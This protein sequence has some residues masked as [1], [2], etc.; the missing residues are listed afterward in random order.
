[1]CSITYAYRHRVPLLTLLA[2]AVPLSPLCVAGL[3][4]TGM[5]TFGNASQ[6]DLASEPADYPNQDASSG[7]DAAARVGTLT[8]SGGGV[9]GFDYTKIANDGTELP[10]EASLGTGRTDWGCVRDNVTSLMWEVKTADNGPR[11]YTWTYTWYD[12]N[13]STNGGS[14]GTANGGDCYST[15]RCDT[16]KYVADVN[17][18]S[19]CG[20]SDW[21]MP[22]KRELLSLVD[23]STTSPGID[24]DYFQNTQGWY[25]WSS[26]AS[27][28]Y[29]DYAWDVCFGGDDTGYGAKN[30]TYYVRLVRNV[31]Q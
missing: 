4:D 29:P 11:D 31:T 15:G 30:Y 18:A 25:F 8:K 23:Y 6:G 19:L 28:Y 21:R 7:R 14:V 20:H 26:S 9:A 16:E 24:R 12:S 27:A 2:L 1:M 10:A 13:T 22:T 5:S 17:G 3:N